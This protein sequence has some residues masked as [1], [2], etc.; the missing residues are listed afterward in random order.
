MKFVR[1]SERNMENVFGL[2]KN[3]VITGAQSFQNCTGFPI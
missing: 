1:T 2:S 3:L